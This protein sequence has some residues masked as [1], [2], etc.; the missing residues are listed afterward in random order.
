LI[1]V[2]NRV[3]HLLGGADN[4][5]RML[6]FWGMFLPLGAVGSADAWLASRGG[7]RRAGAGGVLSVAS[8]AILLQMAF[9]YLFSAAVKS[10]AD[11]LHGKALSGILTDSFYGKP[12]AARLTGYPGLLAVLTV[13]VLALEW[14]APILLFSPVRTA[15]VRCI[16][17]GLLASMH[18]GIELTMNVGLFSFASLAGLLLFLPPLVWD[19]LRGKRGSASGDARDVAIAGRVSP[20]STRPVRFL[21]A[22]GTCA[23]A[24]AYVLFANLNALPDHLLP[25]TRAPKLELLTVSCG[26]GQEWNMFADSRATNGWCVAR[27]TLADGAQVDLLRQGEPVVWERPHNPAA[28]YPNHRWLKCFVGMAH[29]DARGYQVFR[30]P[31]ADYLC[32]EWNRR[33]AP[34]RRVVDF[35]L[36]FCTEKRSQYGLSLTPTTRRETLLHLDFPPQPTASGQR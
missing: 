14:L 7:A 31:V 10:N 22:Q 30:E 23:L 19:G 34:G 15:G 5:I 33:Q 16:V 12:L 4:L 27:A 11:W 20:G 3:P 24:L 29:T 8:A 28:V 9:M 17:V 35:A 36:L 21:A 1:S 2:H 25:W 32:R 6:L 18:L 13:G 26:L